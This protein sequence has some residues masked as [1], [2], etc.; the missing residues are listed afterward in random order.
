MP[1][2]EPQEPIDAE[3]K[4]II[5]SESRALIKVPDPELFNNPEQRC[6]C[7]LLLD[8]SYSMF[9]T[10]IDELNVGIKQFKEG[11]MKDSLAR[12]RVEMAIIT[13]GNKVKPLSDFQ[14]ADNFQPPTLTVEGET[15]MGEAIIKAIE[16]LQVRKERIRNQG[17]YLNRPWIFLITDGAPTDEWKKA[18]QLVRYGESNKHFAFF[19]VGVTGYNKQI[20]AEI[21]VREPVRLITATKFGE[22]FK[23][24][25]DSLSKVSR[26]QP[27]QQVELEG[28]PHS[29]WGVVD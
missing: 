24:L 1:S 2:Y 22:L 8:T 17:I 12:K 13:F 6:P 18:A 29:S 4:E 28:A 23:W 20:L 26:S 11:L 25:S 19:P 21:S 16:L 15:P 3:Y 27:G 14:T 5:T 9:G 7:V 10:P